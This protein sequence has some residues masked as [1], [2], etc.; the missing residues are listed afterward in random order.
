MTQFV[1]V[2][3]CSVVCYNRLCNNRS[4]ARV[5][6][7]VQ[8]VI[9]VARRTFC[10]SLGF[11]LHP[12]VSCTLVQILANVGESP[13]LNCGRWIYKLFCVFRWE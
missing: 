3:V 8:Q 9:Q 11:I 7:R 12:A 2:S 6:E 13:V 4:V 1:T 10:K 5:N